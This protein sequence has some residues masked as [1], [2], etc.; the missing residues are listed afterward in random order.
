MKRLVPMIQAGL[1]FG[2][3]MVGV[4]MVGVLTCSDV[5]DQRT[6]SVDLEAGRETREQWPTDVVA[7]IDSGNAAYR[8]G[9]VERSL[10]HFRSAVGL[11]PDN[12]TAWFGVFMAANSLGYQATADSALAT[13]R[14]LA[15]G[16][17]LLD[18]SGWDR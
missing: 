10:A 6:D 5:G 11:A 15:P 2:V 12:S 9:R 14:A 4:V 17:S 3:L 7:Q 13:V 16:A 18:P 1:M 8:A